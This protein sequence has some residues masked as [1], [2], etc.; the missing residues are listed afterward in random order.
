MEEET[1]L[2]TQITKLQN[3]EQISD[4]AMNA[5]ISDVVKLSELLEIGFDWYSFANSDEKVEIIRIIFSELSLSQN[6]LQYKCRNGFKA[7]ESRFLSECDLTG[8]RTP[9]AALKRPRP[10]R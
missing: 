10:N 3:D 6:T 2:T 5:V 4:L 1:K 9:I 7:L 8:N